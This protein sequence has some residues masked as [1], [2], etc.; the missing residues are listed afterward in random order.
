M[1]ID[2]IFEL[3]LNSI[4]NIDLKLIFIGIDKV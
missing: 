1:W 3:A 4:I 2:E